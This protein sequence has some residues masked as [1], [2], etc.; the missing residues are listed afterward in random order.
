MGREFFT[1]F[2]N[3]IKEP[4]TWLALAA[5]FVSVATFILVYA[6][7]GELKLILPDRVG[8]Q[9]VGPDRKVEMLLP[10]TFTNT[11]APRTWRHILRVTA[12]LSPQGR[13]PEGTQNLTLAWEYERAFIGERE[14]LKKHPNENSHTVD[15]ADYVGRAFPFSLAGGVSQSKV[16]QML[17]FDKG[18]LSERKLD[19]FTLVV[20][21]LQ[22]QGRVEVTKKY[23]CR[24]EVSSDQ[25]TW[26]SLENTQR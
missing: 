7:P 25:F 4:T 24:D 12:V 5:T 16:F 23:A 10:L 6:D 20:V 1:S 19:N 11:G 15:Y 13:V 22:E 26:C 21:A 17:Q 3:W 9:Y 18:A 14:W 8:L 2:F